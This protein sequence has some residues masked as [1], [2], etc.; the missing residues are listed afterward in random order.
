MI[1][2]NTHNMKLKLKKVNSKK[3][4]EEQGYCTIQLNMPFWGFLDDTENSGIS[5]ELAALLG[6]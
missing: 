1:K 5:D 2:I 4:L 3:Q 6:R